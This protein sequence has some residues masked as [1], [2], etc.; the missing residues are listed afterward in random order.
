MTAAQ[1]ARWR[2][3]AGLTLQDVADALGVTK[4]AVSHW[5][6]GRHPVTSRTVATLRLWAKSAKLP[7]P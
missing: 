2:A 1:F 5:E 6:T 7:A 4:G 3:K